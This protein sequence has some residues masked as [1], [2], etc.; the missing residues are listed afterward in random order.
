MTGSLEIAG[1]KPGAPP[2]HCEAGFQAAAIGIAHAASGEALHLRQHVL[3]IPVLGPGGRD[4]GLGGPCE[5]RPSAV[6]EDVAD[7]AAEMAVL[8]GQ[9]EA[10]RCDRRRNA[11]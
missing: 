5:V 2:V 1:A 7:N 6:Q 3:L 4:P 11:C 8:I 9:R 10:L